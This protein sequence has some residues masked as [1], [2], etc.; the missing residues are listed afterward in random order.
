L[1]ICKC[2]IILL[3]NFLFLSVTFFPSQKLLKMEK[4]PTNQQPPAEILQRIFGCI[5]GK[6]ECRLVCAK[7]CHTVG[8][9]AHFRVIIPRRGECSL[10]K[11]LFDLKR[12]PAFGLSIYSINNIHY[13]NSSE[14]GDVSASESEDARSIKRIFESVLKLCPKLRELNLILTTGIMPKY[15]T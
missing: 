15:L 9:T 6:R 2:G 13:T 7:W 14:E 8:D 10:E 11:L 5:Q 4:L 12:N 3:C 1:F